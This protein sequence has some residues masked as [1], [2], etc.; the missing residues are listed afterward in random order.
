M[1]EI[2]IQI[3][4]RKSVVKPAKCESSMEEYGRGKPSLAR[5]LDLAANASEDYGSQN[6]SRLVICL[7]SVLQGTIS[8]D[9]ICDDERY[10][11]SANRSSN[12]LNCLNCWFNSITPIEAPIIVK[13]FIS[14]ICSSFKGAIA[15]P[16]LISPIISYYILYIALIGL[17]DLHLPRTSISSKRQHHHFVI[18][19]DSKLVLIRRGWSPSS[20]DPNLR[21]IPRNEFTLNLLMTIGW[22]VSL[23]FRIVMQ[24]AVRII[25]SLFL[26]V[27]LLK[28]TPRSLL[29]KF[30]T[31]RCAAS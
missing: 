14:F 10:A 17:S 11:P 3:V 6:D 24:V 19:N 31:C 21:V 23:V 5:L 13:I 26:E 28:F 29:L 20:F 25:W 22:S 9:R 7:S 2:H 27:H 1:E 8:R 4:C 30:I 12:K 15:L 16:L 18:S